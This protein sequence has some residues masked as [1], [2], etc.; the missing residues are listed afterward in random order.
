M[1]VC[2]CDVPHPPHSDAVRGE[3]VQR[4]G[5]KLLESSPSLA[6]LGS[7]EKV[8]GLRDIE[9]ALFNNNGHL[10]RKSRLFSF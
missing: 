2:V 5:Q 8:P 1:C 3:D 10:P 6:V 4:V 7:V 9:K